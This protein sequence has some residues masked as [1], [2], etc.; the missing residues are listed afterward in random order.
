MLDPEI[1]IPHQND[2]ELPPPLQDVVGPS[3]VTHKFLPK[4]GEIDGLDG[5]LFK[6]IELDDGR[7]DTVFQ[8][9]KCIS[10]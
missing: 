4:Q 10:C 7:L 8:P 1:R 3:K 5:L 9:Q 2:F 6:I